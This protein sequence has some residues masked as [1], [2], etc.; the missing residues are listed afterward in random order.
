MK[1][2][3]MF[4]FISVML[5]SLVSANG[6]R[7]IPTTITIN[8]TVE[9]DELVALTIHNDEPFTFY[10]ITIDNEDYPYLTFT[11]INELASGANV[12]VS[13]I[14]KAD[15]DIDEVVKVSG[16]YM[17]NVGEQNLLHEVNI[18]GTDDSDVNPCDF[19]IV[20]G[21]S[22]KWKNVDA[23]LQLNLR[24]WGQVNQQGRPTP[25]DGAVIA[26]DQSFTKQF[27]TEGLLD[28]GIFLGDTDSFEIAR[29]K[30][31]IRPTSGL[32]HD[33]ALD[34]VFHLK[35]K[36][37]Y[38][39]TT[40]NVL[41]AETRTSF[42]PFIAQEGGVISITNTGNKT[43]KTIHLSGEWFK[44][45]KNDFDLAVG[46]TTS[47]VYDIESVVTST[48]DT[49]KTYTKNM[50]ITGN[51]DSYSRQFT[52]F[53]EYR[54]NINPDS[55]TS[56]GGI[57]EILRGFCERNPEICQPVIVQSEGNGSQQ[58]GQWNVTQEQFRDI[59]VHIFEEEEARQ[60]LDNYIKEEISK[61]TGDSQ[62]NTQQ[63]AELITMMLT[64]KDDQEASVKTMIIFIIVVFL[65]VASAIAGLLIYLKRSRDK[66]E[67]LRRY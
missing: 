5:I 49:N 58:Q 4:A 22:V 23:F 20:K 43:A 26:R 51:F 67:A 8:K 18:T 3:F 38:D 50:S 15:Q 16:F 45:S 60:T 54:A 53:L 46:A 66:N 9:A 63:I 37:N 7:V 40:I 62:N 36:T 39:P 52:L 57:D 44:F 27:T 56:S 34:G 47:V 2:W 55:P 17:S 31:T 33:P 11:K 41:V 64:T 10:N 13:A 65:I 48:L 29:C 25:I 32:V 14:L 12:T 28:Y 35:V 61:L 24:D 42:T 1:R 59:W 30:I 21:D 6:L 19:W